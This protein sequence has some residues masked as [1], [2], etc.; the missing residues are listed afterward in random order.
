MLDQTE[1]DW[2][3]DQ[4]PAPLPLD[5]ETTSRVRADL[6][7]HTTGGSA[8]TAGRSRSLRRSA[9]V[10]RVG[11]GGLTLAGAASV[12]LLATG[13]GAGHVVGGG[14][15]LDPL[16]V[17]TA[18]AKQLSH[19]SARLAAAP[20]PVGDATLV[21]RR[22]VYPKGP[23]VDGAD[24][25]ADNGD[26]YYSPALAGLPAI[27][28]SGQTVNS[29]SSDAE[30]RDIAAAKA[31]L[32]GSISKVRYQMSV[33][34]FDPA[35]LAHHSWKTVYP[36]GARAKVE[37]AHARA[38]ENDMTAVISHED[39]MIWSNGM[40]ALLTGAGDPQVRAG[41][42][43][44]F[45]TIPQVTVTN[46]TLNGHQTLDLTATL[47]SSNQGLYQE[48][49]VLDAGTGIPIEMIGGNKDQ[50]PEVTAYYTISRV[51]VTDVENGT[52]G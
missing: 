16:T 3:A 25:F 29:S 22:Y 38:H 27:I 13:G 30:V 19:L 20:P 9:R 26:Y 49:L 15:S 2:L 42:L 41:V 40:D 11:V 46:G 6:L 37:Q 51:T 8:A 45:S 14:L 33:A 28:K 23:E 43:K 21:L 35:V 5:P 52:G 17:Q 18:A 48:K 4:R 34:N 1:L 24:L 39:G 32:T 47:L 10:L 7:R 36:P 12:A 44:L 50:A 31:A